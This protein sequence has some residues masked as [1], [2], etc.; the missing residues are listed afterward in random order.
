MINDWLMKSGVEVIIVADTVLI[1]LTIL[2]ILNIYFNSYC[3][4]VAVTDIIKPNKSGF[5]GGRKSVLD[6][7]ISICVSLEHLHIENI[8]L[9]SSDG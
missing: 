7:R 9:Y 1:T 8:K 3:R 5:H 4:P 2:N 6:N